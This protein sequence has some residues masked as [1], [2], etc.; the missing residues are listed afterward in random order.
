M[1][2][3]LLKLE[4]PELQAIAKSKAEQI[5]STFEPMAVMLSDFEESYNS[6]IQEAENEITRDVTMKAKRLRLDIG[7]VRIETGKKKDKAKEYLKLEDRA[8]MGVHNILVYAV[9][10]KED[11]LKEI[12][13]YFE[14]QEKKRLEKLQSDRAEQLSKYVEDAYERDLAKFE[15]DEFQALL[16]MKKKEKEDRIAAEKK[17]EQERIAKEKAEAEE[18]ERIRKENEKLKAEAEERERLAKIEADKRA[19]EEAKRQAKA[20]AERKAQAE[21]ERKAKEAYEAKLKAEREEKERIQRELEA[22]AEAERKTKAEEQARIEKELNKGDSHK[23]K[24]LVNDLKNLKTKYSFKSAKNK[25]MYED[26]GLLID[27]LINHIQK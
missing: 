16:S 6:I 14:I 18:R 19:K 5:K 23:V 11:K 21:K 24:D 27:K 8:I 10:E 12:E 1:T 4:M 26:V 2:H 22:K 3:E 15:E 25:K 20:E 13:N 17:A 7:K 9:K